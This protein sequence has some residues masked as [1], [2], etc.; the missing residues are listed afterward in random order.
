MLQAVF[1]LPLN[2]E[3]NTSITLLAQSVTSPRSTARLSQTYSEKQLVRV[4]AGHGGAQ[5]SMQLMHLF[6]FV[7]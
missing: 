4:E 2:S 6:W 1:F 5:E 7:F 3:N